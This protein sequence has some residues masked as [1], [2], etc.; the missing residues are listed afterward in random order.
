M[1]INFNGQIDARLIR[2]QGKITHA[3]F[4]ASFNS[5]LFKWFHKLRAETLHKAPL[6]QSVTLSQYT[7]CVNTKNTQHQS[8]TETY[9]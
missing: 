7:I 8:I 9:G 1:H 3:A 5:L 4:C 6:S 2:V